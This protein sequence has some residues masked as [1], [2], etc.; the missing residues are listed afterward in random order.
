MLTIKPF[1]D[2]GWHTV[3]LTGELH[4][5]EGG[6]KTIPNYPQSW[7][8][9]YTK[10]KNTAATK[11]GGVITGKVSGIIAIDCDNEATY[12]L[13][14]CLDPEYKFLFVSKGKGKNS[15]TIVYKYYEGTTPTFSIKNDSLELDIYTDKGFVYLPTLNNKT[16]VS[17]ASVQEIR[18]APDC[19]KTLLKQLYLLYS[20]KRPIVAEVNKSH[21]SYLAP[22][23]NEFVLRGE[24]MAGLFK[25]ITPR[26]FRSEPEYVKRGYLHP[27]NVPD[28]AGSEYLSKLSAI[29]GADPSVDEELYVKAMHTVNALW[30]SPMD[31][32]RLD[33]TIC[34]P[35]ISHSVTING[36]V[37]WQ[38]EE[39]W[40]KNRLVL[41]TK[42]QN[43]IEVAYDDYRL[44][45]YVIDLANERSQMFESDNGLQAHLEATVI[46]P[47]AKKTLKYKMPIINVMSSP[48]TDFG[49]SDSLD[50]TVRDFNPF[51]RSPEL[52][53]LNDPE[54]YA[55]QYKE[56]R[57]TIKYLE[58]LIPEKIMRD[59]TLGFLKY[60]LTTF[61][62]S[63]AVLFFLGVHGSGKDTFV[64]ILEKIMG[65]V[66]RPKASEFLEKNNAW[67]LDTYFVQLDEYGN[68]L[69]RI[70]E[71]DEALGLL[72]AYSGKAQTSIR[73][74]R[75]DGIAY[76]HNATF[77]MTQ[78]KQPLMMED[79]DRRIV[80][81]HTP[82][83]LSTQVWVKEAGGITKV[84]DTIMSEVKDF[85]YYLATSVTSISND[86]YMVPPYSKYKHQIIAD[87][88]FAAQR[89]AYAIRNGMQ[90][91][92]VDLADEYN[93]NKASKAFASADVTT[94]DIESLY[95]EMTEYKG[96]VRALIKSLRGA[97]IVMTPTTVG[98]D[99]VLRLNLNWVTESPFGDDDGDVDGVE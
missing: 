50:A 5:I 55:S 79:G 45:Y 43:S 25:I 96:N 46:D 19:V 37:I 9:K 12:N 64:A 17:W 76:S 20:N 56:P 58:T 53:I 11:I 41:K 80:F 4:R 89:L 91:Y 44:M 93:N 94:G 8:D 85:C 57:T 15:G 67:L 31:S 40:E 14:R 34:D 3:P 36:E 26:S 24:F 65:R 61:K 62:Y 87:S 39:F 63:S 70:S 52:R 18:E 33:K 30:S 16:K 97:G 28:G 88:M 98:G 73:T 2:L 49:F 78:N 71:K 38:Y 60:K 42:R 72:K 54:S 99:K 95:D 35:M 7:R 75:N 6:E 86:A 10:T 92:L 48:A 21:T 66:A 29:F 81:L 68:Q 77:V 84:Y 90:Q 83:V 27:D 82:H 47:L 23:I 22:L 74:M 13:F 32:D 1:I 69:T 59:Y 51:V